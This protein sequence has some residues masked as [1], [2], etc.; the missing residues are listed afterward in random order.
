MS[1]LE[2]QNPVEVTSR[3]YF[4]NTSRGRS[5]ERAPCVLVLARVWARRR[6]EQKREA[7]VSQNA[8]G[9]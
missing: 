8:L 3:R 6:H 5:R 7:A 9:P 1:R 2:P 4:N